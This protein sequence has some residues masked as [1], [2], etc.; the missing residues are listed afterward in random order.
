MLQPGPLGA[1]LTISTPTETPP[2]A[3]GT[4]NKI[5]VTQR[6]LMKDLELLK[7]NREDWIVKVELR[8]DV[9]TDWEVR[10][11]GPV[12]FRIA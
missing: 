12:C 2:T 11:K 10:I 5:N 9:I 8:G 3:Q 6:R 7:K 4:P 1:R